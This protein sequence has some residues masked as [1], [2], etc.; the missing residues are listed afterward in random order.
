MLQICKISTIPIFYEMFGEIF[1]DVKVFEK[2]GKYGLKPKY[3]TFAQISVVRAT[4]PRKSLS[5]K[6]RQVGHLG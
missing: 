3:A 5:G 4:T 1:E 6:N 2:R